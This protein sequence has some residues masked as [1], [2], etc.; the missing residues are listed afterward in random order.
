[1]KLAILAV[2]TFLSGIAHAN[3][4]CALHQ[5]GSLDLKEHAG[6]MLTIP[7]MIDGKPQTMAI[8]PSDPNS[9]LAAEYG[10]AQNFERAVV[11]VKRDGHIFIPK[12]P[13]YLVTDFMIGNIHG[14]KVPM[15]RFDRPKDFGDDVVGEV[16]ADILSN[17][18]V[19]VDLKNSKII[20]FSQD[21]CPGNVVYWTKSK[22]AAIPFDI[23]PGGH[24]SVQM[25][26]DGKTISVT[27]ALATGGA[28]MSLKAAKRIF[29]I[30]ENSQGVT[31]IVDAPTNTR[32]YRFPFKVLSIDGISILN[33]KIDLDP[34]IMECRLPHCFG[35]SDVYLG[36]D[37]L[38]Y[39]HFY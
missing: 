32:R 11:P 25:N 39:L 17:F 3:E 6:R 23:D 21:H 30:D 2:T 15:H 33:P 4:Q 12:N 20:L 31:S 7:V 14:T 13:S 36:T 28:S 16:G 9:L 34:A 29:G 26:L 18:D 27:F 24:S 37:E 35:G 1:M 10:D 38:R 8:N 5:V 22:Y 19:E